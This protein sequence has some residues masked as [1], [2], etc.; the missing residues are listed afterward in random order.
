MLTRENRLIEALPSECRAALLAHS[1]I[2]AL[3]QEQML[4][5]AGKAFDY[6]YFPLDAIVSSLYFLKSGYGTE[7]SLAGNEGVIGIASF[8]H[9][10]WTRCSS[11]VRKAG[12]AYRITTR[13]LQNEFAERS[14]LRNVLLLYVQSLMTETAQAAVCKRYHSVGQQLCLLLLNYLDHFSVSTLDLTHEWIAAT[15]GVRRE[16]VTEAAGR[17]RDAG[18]IDYRR[19]RITV[20][21][22]PQ[23]E[24]ECCDC[25]STLHH[26]KIR[27]RSAA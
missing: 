5:E 14:E 9:G 19:G 25:Y 27:L 4:H 3:E 13:A 22:R 1:A 17:L 18:I 21:D 26:G 10:G 7:I 11:Q 2:V 24:E 15:L 12:Q 8:L 20:L 23:L 16:G 6:V